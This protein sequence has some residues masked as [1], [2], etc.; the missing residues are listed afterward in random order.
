[1]MGLAWSLTTIKTPNLQKIDV[2]YGRDEYDRVAQY[3]LDE[4]KIG[5]NLRVLILRQID[6]ALDKI[7]KEHLFT[8]RNGVTA[9]EPAFSLGDDF[10]L[11]SVYRY[12]RASVSYQEVE[13]MTVVDEFVHREVSRFGVMDAETIQLNTLHLEKDIE[14]SPDQFTGDYDS[15]GQ[16][17]NQAVYEVQYRTDKIGQLQYQA[18]Y[19]ANNELHSETTYEYEDSPLGQL[20]QAAHLL[21]HTYRNYTSV[22]TESNQHDRRM[23]YRFIN[24]VSSFIPQRLR[25]ATHTDHRRNITTVSRPLAHD[26]YTGEPLK[27]VSDDSY[28]NRVVSEKVP[29]FRKIE[30]MGLAEDGGT[31]QLTVPAATQTYYVDS[32]KPLNEL[33]EAD[34]TPTG[35]YRSRGAK[36]GVITTKRYGVRS[37]ATFGWAAKHYRPTALIRTIS[38]PTN[39]STGLRPTNPRFGRHRKKSL[40]IIRTVFLC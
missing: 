38:S 33:T 12:P 1:M 39:P 32:T 40:H 16:K 27:T 8:Y 23:T 10:D 5:G 17:L 35:L 28:G 15:Y 34:L 37:K 31:N 13:K 19:D 2:S 21:D 25:S 3:N 7:V 36:N 18:L 24:T 4:E 14:I 26:F 29:A 30:G 11:P 9:S 6:L 22:P 20:S